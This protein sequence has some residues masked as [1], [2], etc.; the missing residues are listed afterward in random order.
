[1]WSN[2][3]MKPPACTFPECCRVQGVQKQQFVS[4]LGNSLR[5]LIAKTKIPNVVEDFLH[6]P[7]RQHSNVDQRQRSGQYQS[8][9]TAGG[10]APKPAAKPLARGVQVVVPPPLPETPPRNPLAYTPC[11]LLYRW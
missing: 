3:L 11:L 5:C 4:L 6:A 10:N 7:R 2:V 1:M 9:N 8:I